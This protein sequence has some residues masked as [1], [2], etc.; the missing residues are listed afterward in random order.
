[1]KIYIKVIYKIK[2]TSFF[3]MKFLYN[4]SLIL[5]LNFFIIIDPNII[6]RNNF[7]FNFKYNHIQIFFNYD[8]DDV[9]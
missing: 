8:V 5:M 6:I 1:M 9:S 3:V 7:L 2:K 4:N